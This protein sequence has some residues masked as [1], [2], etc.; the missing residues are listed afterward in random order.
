M[1]YPCL[2]FDLVENGLSFLS[3][4]LFPFFS[5]PS[6]P[7]FPFLSFI[8]RYVSKMKQLAVSLA[9]YKSKIRIS[10]YAAIQR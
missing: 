8:S 5:F 7:S 10:I 9:K 6:L 1:H 3:L 4:P 2:R